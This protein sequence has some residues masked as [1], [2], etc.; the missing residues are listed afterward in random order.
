MAL[1]EE[2]LYLSVIMID[3][4]SIGLIIFHEIIKHLEREGEEDENHK[5]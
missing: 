4:I 3:L 2:I 1:L 5:F